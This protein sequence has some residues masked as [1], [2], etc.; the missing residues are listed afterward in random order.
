MSTIRERED[1]WEG[2]LISELSIV[3]KGKCRVSIKTDRGSYDEVLAELK[4]VYSSLEYSMPLYDPAIK[5]IF[6]GQEME[7]ADLSEQERILIDTVVQ[8]GLAQKKP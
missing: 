4:V 7:L 2:D 5:T 8:I 3:G 6:V 1:G